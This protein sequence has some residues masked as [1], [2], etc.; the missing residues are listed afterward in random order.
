SQT[1]DTVNGWGDDQWQITLSS[2]RSVSIQVADCCIVGDNY[3]VYVDSKLI[4]T[5]PSEPL[6]GSTYSQ[7][8]FTT[9]LTAGSHLITIRDPGGLDYYRQGYTFMI[10]AGYYVTITTSQA[11]GKG[12]TGLD[13]C[14]LQKGDILLE[15]ANDLVTQAVSGF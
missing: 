8:T 2:A 5:T 12:A 7:G 15:T 14:Q 4:G 9:V 13:T 1:S 3:E 10:P 11:C 6:S